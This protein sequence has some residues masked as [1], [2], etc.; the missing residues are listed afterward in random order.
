MANNM[1]QYLHFRILKFPWYPSNIES[2]QK[3]SICKRQDI[4]PSSSINQ[5]FLG[6]VWD[7]TIIHHMYTLGISQ[8]HAIWYDK[9]VAAK[10]AK[11]QSSLQRLLLWWPEQSSN[12]LL[13]GYSLIIFHSL[14]TG[15]WPIETLD[16]LIKD[17][18]F[19]FA[20]TSFTAWLMGLS[21]GLVLK[22]LIYHLPPRRK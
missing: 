21:H 18:D 7:A 15:K 3:K 5:N 13:V 6:R 4:M 12:L 16:L 1:V 9:E 22:M 10:K 2:D 8:H 11:I 20:K 14:R 19:P 17:C